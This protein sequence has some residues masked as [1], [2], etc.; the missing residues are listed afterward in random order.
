MELVTDPALVDEDPFVY[1]GKFFKRFDRDTCE[2]VSNIKE[3][4][5]DD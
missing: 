3:Q 2:F 5:P 1:A 4:F